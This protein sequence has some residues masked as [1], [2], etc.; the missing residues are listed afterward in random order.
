VKG[1]VSR[2]RGELR[3]DSRVGVGTRVTVRIPIN[4]EPEPAAPFKRRARQ[5]HSVSALA[6]A[7][8]RW[9]NGG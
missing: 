1:L 2:H 5:S 9:A 4:A 8:I 6:P 7:A 3:V